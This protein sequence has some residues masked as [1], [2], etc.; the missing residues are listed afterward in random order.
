MAWEKFWLNFG[1]SQFGQADGTPAIQRYLTMC[2]S[3]TVTDV[4]R[5]QRATVSLNRPLSDSSDETLTLGDTFEDPSPSPEDSVVD[6]ASRQLF[7]QLVDSHTQDEK[8]RAV[9][10]LKYELGLTSAEIHTRRPDL[11]STRDDVYRVTRNV[12]DRLR[13]SPEMRKWLDEGN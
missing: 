8:E 5:N 4:I 10:Y 13:R 1:P 11:F 3:S 7:K 2:V 12:L 9:L 6:E